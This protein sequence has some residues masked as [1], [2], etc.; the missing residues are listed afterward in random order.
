[1]KFVHSIESSSWLQ[2]VNFL[3]VPRDKQQVHNGSRPIPGLLIWI[4]IFF[5]PLWTVN[6]WKQMFD[7]TAPYFKHWVL[8]CLA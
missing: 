3:L 8:V 1:M 5:I 2:I 4:V 7:K 6:F